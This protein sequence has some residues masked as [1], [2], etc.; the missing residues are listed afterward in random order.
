[1]SKSAFKLTARYKPALFST[2][3][4]TFSPNRIPGE[5]Q[6]R[7]KNTTFSGIFIPILNFQ[8]P[9]KPSAQQKPLS[10]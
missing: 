10:P 7:Y 2:I 5:P 6:N 9:P 4:T 1:M 8:S 3:F